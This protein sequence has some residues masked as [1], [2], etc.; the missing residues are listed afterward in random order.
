M[1]FIRFTLLPALGLLCASLI[2]HLATA[3]DPVDIDSLPKVMTPEQLKPIEDLFIQMAAHR[4]QIIYYACDI[5]SSLAADTENMPNS[6]GHNVDGFKPN[7]MWMH[8]DYSKPDGYRLAYIKQTADGPIAFLSGMS[9]DLDI[10]FSKANGMQLQDTRFGERRDLHMPYAFDPL[11][12]GLGFWGDYSSGRSFD[13]VLK[14]HLDNCNG[15]TL[16][17]LESLEDGV[18]RIRQGSVT[19]DIDTRRGYWPIRYELVD[20]NPSNNQSSLWQLELK[21]VKKDLYLPSYAKIRY[22]QPGQ[23]LIDQQL[24]FHWLS[25]NERIAIGAKAAKLLATK[26]EIPLEDFRAGARR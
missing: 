16:M 7:Q 19:I 10:V 1:K 5:E 13:E 21:E 15:I 25:V 4:G 2:C 12:V 3:A 20:H 26:H 17:K 18:V 22:R 6:N 8:F 14:D 9:K 24:T 11:V 23:G